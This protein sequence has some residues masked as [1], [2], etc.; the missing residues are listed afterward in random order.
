[1]VESYIPTKME[2]EM[3][4]QDISQVELAE[5]LGVSQSTISLI[6]A[7]KRNLTLEL[8]GTIGRVL[9]MD[10]TTLLEPFTLD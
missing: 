6:L 5:M 9:G 3:R 7:R 8:A 1:M 10:S 4:K 2:V